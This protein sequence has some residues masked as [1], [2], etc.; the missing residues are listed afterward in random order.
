[1]ALD[2]ITVHC[3]VDELSRLLTDGRI[4]KIHQPQK[5]EISMTIRCF[6]TNYRLLLSAS[7]SHPRAQITSSTKENPLQAPMF[8]MVLRKHLSGSKITRIHQPGCERILFLETEGRNE[9]GDVAQKTLVLE[10]MGKYSNLI[11]VD[12]QTGLILDSIKHV[13]HEIS[14]VREVL[15][16]KAYQLPPSQN[17]ADGLLAT[18]ASFLSVLS[19]KQ[20]QTIEK[21]IYQ[22]FTGI[23]PALAAEICTR[24]DLYGATRVEELTDF[25]QN[26]LAASFCALMADVKENLWAPA[27][28]YDEKGLPADFSPLPY[29][30]W[31]GKK[32]EFS[33]ISA[34]IEAFYGRRDTM[35][36]IRQK[37]H[38]MRR[39]VQSNI[40]RC[41]KKKEIQL[42]TRQDNKNMEKWRLK[43]EL[44]TANIYA[45]PKNATTFS[46]VNFYDESM[47]QV[48]IA[49]DPTL[50]PAENAA[51]YFQK[52]NKAK[53][54]LAAL[55]IQEEQN[56]KELAYLEGVL[57]AIDACTEEADLKD[58]RDELIS[59]GFLRHKGGKKQDKR[60]KKSRPMHFL[61]SDG[62]H[63]YVG[64]SNLQNDELTLR[65][66]K[67][68]DIWLHTK[69]LPG[70][71]VII[72][73]DNHPDAVPEQTMLEAANL[74][75][76]YS[77]GK[78]SSK[79]PVD[80]CLRRFVKKPNGAKPGMVIYETNQTFY[81]TPDRAMA[82]TM[83]PAQEG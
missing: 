6:G 34:V 45:I 17:K 20:G 12:Q 75:A 21:A 13:T 76:F 38:D 80:Y 65:F 7:A 28:Y 32:E 26:T 1:M 53:R 16:G 78:D 27:L 37:A 18:P 43:G 33:S 39:L 79:V 58:I 63:I 61:S 19:E 54:T 22:S 41:V 74:A 2:G 42:R 30:N 52:Y 82:E 31:N 71:H 5:D 25:Q 29:T 4:D 46:A 40:E 72:A 67:S 68:N 55:A 49:L 9:M 51:R 70:S 81:I 47:P 62:Y 14:S 69:N 15:P 35:Y 11:L 23:S 66:A 44:I 77:K 60:Q 56:D 48:E 8:C 83:R 24:A 64:K 3:I 57:V 50:S 10:L 59:E 36:H 73:T